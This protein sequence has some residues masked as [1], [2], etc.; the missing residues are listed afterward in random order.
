MS[1]VGCVLH[2][3]PS[4]RVLGRIRLKH[5]V[6]YLHGEKERNEPLKGFAG[7]GLDDVIGRFFGPRLDYLLS[8]LRVPAGFGDYLLD[9]L[10]YAFE[11]YGKKLAHRNLL[12]KRA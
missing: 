3:H 10:T 2:R 6:I 11:F 8:K 7:R 1:V 4:C 5:E 12:A 9:R